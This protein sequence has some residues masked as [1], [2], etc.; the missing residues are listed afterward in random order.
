ME[1]GRNKASRNF[2]LYAQK[3][4]SMEAGGQKTLL[5]AARIK[6]YLCGHHNNSVFQMVLE[7]EIHSFV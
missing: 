6:T 3:I 1:K 4:A 7:L 2:G 5:A